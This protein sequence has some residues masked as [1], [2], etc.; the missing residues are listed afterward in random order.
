M[1]HCSYLGCPLVPILK[2][3]LKTVEFNLPRILLGKNAQVVTFLEDKVEKLSEI[4][5]PL[6]AVVDIIFSSNEKA[7]TGSG[8]M[9]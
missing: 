2:Q 5:S 6:V 3:T 7:S 4:K 9:S 1:Q 8:S